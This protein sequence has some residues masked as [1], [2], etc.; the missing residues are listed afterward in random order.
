MVWLNHTHS[1]MFM[2]PHIVHSAF[3]AHTCKSW[4]PRTAVVSRPRAALSSSTEHAA[5][6][7]IFCSGVGVGGTKG[8]SIDWEA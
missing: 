6:A 4:R 2:L 1:V 5:A 7:I 3:G 8:F